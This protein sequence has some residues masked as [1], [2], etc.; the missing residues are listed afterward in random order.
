MRGIGSYHALSIGMLIL[1]EKL[2]A[3][4]RAIF[5]LKEIFAYDYTSWRKFSIKHPIAAG[6]YSDGEG[7]ISERSPTL[8]SRH[9]SCMKKC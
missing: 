6:K 8:R 3:Q 7:E 9:E 5:L 1:L 4:E 2:T